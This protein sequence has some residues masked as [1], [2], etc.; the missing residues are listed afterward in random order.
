MKTFKFTK[1]KNVLTFANKIYKLEAILNDRSIILKLN[2][3]SALIDDDYD[4]EQVILF[5][6]NI[7]KENEPYKRGVNF[8]RTTMRYDSFPK[9]NPI[10]ITMNGEKLTFSKDDSPEFDK[11]IDA[12]FKYSQY[13]NSNPKFQI[14]NATHTYITE[15]QEYKISAIAETMI[16][17][18]DD[19]DKTLSS[20]FAVFPFPGIIDDIPKTTLK[21][22]FTPKLNKRF[23]I[24]IFAIKEGG[25]HYLAF[26]LDNAL[27]E[28]WPF[29]SLE[30]YS[31]DRSENLYNYL[32]PDYDKAT[33]K[34]C[35]G[36]KKYE[37]LRSDNI[38]SEDYVDQNIF[39]H[40]W[41]LWFIYQILQGIK[42]SKTMEQ[43]FTLLD[44]SC[45]TPRENLLTIKSFALWLS[46]NVLDNLQIPH[47]NKIYQTVEQL[48]E[49]DTGLDIYE[50][51]N[52]TTQ[53]PKTFDWDD[54]E[55]PS[56]V[57]IEEEEEYNMETEQ[58]RMIRL[59]V[60]GWI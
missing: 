33:T 17:V 37:P 58:E 31:L 7:H 12:I 2:G 48:A 41:S 32:Y 29:D 10:N 53:L 46:A 57:D 49:T 40:T 51:I 24:G 23:N 6:D 3:K 22:M 26:I 19:E 50:L 11:F 18:L 21:K 4:L 47:F 59:S 38:S 35:S 52:D 1:R 36:C 25:D 8:T 45:G 27:K 60:G 16:T 34:I 56:K 15:M 39:C 54:V 43:L 9:G 42:E 30:T 13:I 14:L 55:D 20:Q 28:L 5:L 44:N